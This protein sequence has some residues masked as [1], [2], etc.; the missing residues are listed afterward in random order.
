M[1]HS[2][3]NRKSRNRPVEVTTRNLLGRPA[4]FDVDPVTNE[5]YIAD[6]YLNHRIIVFD[7]GTG[8]YLRHWG[9]YGKKPD[10]SPQDPMTQK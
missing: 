6:G 1:G 10:D 9:A 3:S 4:D 8:K 5:V 7:A 2:F